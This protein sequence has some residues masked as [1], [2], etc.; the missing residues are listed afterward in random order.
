VALIDG[1]AD[2]KGS[3][4]PAQAFLEF[5][6]SKEA[7]EIEARHFFRPRDPAILAAHKSDFPIL[8]LATIDGDFGGWA[9]AQAIHFADGGLFD[10]I[11]QPG[12]K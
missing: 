6:Y 10:Q 11:Y 2:K 7:Q 4:K 9:K 1:T 12:A 3:R 8:P 5:L